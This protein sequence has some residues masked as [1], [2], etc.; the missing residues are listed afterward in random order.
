M[1]EYPVFVPRVD[2]DGNETG[3]IR[4]ADLVAPLGTHAGWNL[5]APGF[6]EDALCGNSGTFIPF[7]ATA[8]ERLAS[9]DPRLSL[10]ERYGTHEAY[11]LAVATAAQELVAERFLLPEDAE[12]LVRL[13][14]AAKTGLPER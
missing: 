5:R 4:A 6:I 1:S 7:A 2:Q 9:G 8:A 14:E 13:A 10:E 12:R 11:V 3:G